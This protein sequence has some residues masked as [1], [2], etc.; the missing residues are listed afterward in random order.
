MGRSS[1]VLTLYRLTQRKNKGGK[2]LVLRT[3]LAMRPDRKVE[4]DGHE[5][6]ANLF[7]E[8]NE[9][10]A[11]ELSHRR[12]L[13]YGMKGRL[14]RAGEPDS[15]AD[16]IWAEIWNRTDRPEQSVRFEGKG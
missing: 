11:R 9:S 12:E 6:D 2:K 3:L 15:F 5:L 16:D 4:L 13:H 8:I 14:N 7:M 10:I 1:G